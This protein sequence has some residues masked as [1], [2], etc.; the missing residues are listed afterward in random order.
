MPFA[1]L[2]YPLILKPQKPRTLIAAFVS[3]NMCSAICVL[4]LNLHVLQSLVA[5]LSILLSGIWNYRWCVRTVDLV[6]K[7]DGLWRGQIGKYTFNEAMLL[8]GSISNRLFVYLQIRAESG[9]VLTTF[10]TRDS[11]DADDFRRLRV[12]LL[13]DGK[14]EAPGRQKPF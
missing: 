10:L 12:R 7:S 1:Q 5:L 8:P 13:I 14:R 9:R 6:W 4:G 2:A 3:L 11:L